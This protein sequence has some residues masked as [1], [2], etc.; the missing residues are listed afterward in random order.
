MTFLDQFGDGISIA[1]G[2][3]VI[4]VRE[5]LH[6]DKNIYFF[7][8]YFFTYKVVGP[9]NNSF[10]HLNVFWGKHRKKI[11]NKNNLPYPP[12]RPYPTLYPTLPYP[13][14]PECS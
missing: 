8:W 6:F 5:H 1:V 10:A 14:L 13:T 3:I 2:F 9:K 4:R 7:V 12:Y 11:K